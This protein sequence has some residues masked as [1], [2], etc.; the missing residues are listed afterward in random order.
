[1]YPFAA[2]LTTSGEVRKHKIVT[3]AV[4]RHDSKVTQKLIEIVHYV[5]SQQHYVYSVYPTLYLLL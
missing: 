5:A 4:H 2:K 1:M 3:E